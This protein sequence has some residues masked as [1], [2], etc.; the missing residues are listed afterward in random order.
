[1]DEVRSAVRVILVDGSGRTLL[2]RSVDDYWFTPGGGLDEGEDLEAAA[3]REVLEEVGLEFGSLGEPLGSEQI[4]F[5][6]EGRRI[7]QFQTYFRVRL[8]GF[9][10]VLSAGFTEE[11]LRGVT[12]HRWWSREEISATSELIYPAHLLDWL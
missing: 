10:E 6:F 5:V 8:E 4:E 7:V 3:R 2:F 11:E 12:A 1:M 9:H